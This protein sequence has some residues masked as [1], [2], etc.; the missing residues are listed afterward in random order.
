[1]QA[2]NE[3]LRQRI[4]QTRQNVADTCRRIAGSEAQ[5]HLEARNTE[6]E[7]NGTVGVNSSSLAKLT[8]ISRPPSTGHDRMRKQWAE[9]KVFQIA[10]G[11]RSVKPAGRFDR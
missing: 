11:R 8:S 3:R 2:A 4:D 7:R 9:A 6:W 10:D 5:L 1:M